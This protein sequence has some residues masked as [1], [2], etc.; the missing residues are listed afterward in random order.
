MI[1]FFNLPVALDYSQSSYF[2][3]HTKKEAR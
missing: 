2:W 1:G 3:D